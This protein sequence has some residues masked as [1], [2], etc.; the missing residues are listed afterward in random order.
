MSSLFIYDEQYKKILRLNNILM[1]QSQVQKESPW[2]LSNCIEISLI[3]GVL[4]TCSRMNKYQYF[5]Q[6][7]FLANQGSLKQIEFLPCRFGSMELWVLAG[8]KT[9][10]H[11]IQPNNHYSSLCLLFQP[12]NKSHL[13]F[14]IGILPNIFGRV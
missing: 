10:I 14:Q 7:H 2:Q 13:L 1:K 11:L 4:K 12:K 9:L 8:Q 5:K 6:L 3:A